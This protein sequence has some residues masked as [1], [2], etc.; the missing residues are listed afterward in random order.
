MKRRKKYALLPL[1]II[2]LLVGGCS[3]A[4]SKGEVNLIS[5]HEG[6]KIE[7]QQAALKGIK[8]AIQYYHSSNDKY[9]ENIR[10]IQ[11]LMGSP[12]DPEMYQ[13]NPENGMVKLKEQ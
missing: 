13:Y 2:L 7:G 3:P 4:P 1:I 6:A 5:A 9:P 11:K 10:E 12:I 8:N